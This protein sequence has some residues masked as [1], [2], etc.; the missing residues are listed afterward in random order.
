MDYKKIG[1]FIAQE[2]KVKNLTQEALAKKLYVSAKTISKWE[3]GNG[4]PD[5]SILTNLCAILEVT[6]N[7]LL[8][9][10]RLDDVDYKEKAENNIT[11]IYEEGERK[12]K[13]HNKIMNWIIAFIVATIYITVSLPT[14]K[15]EYTWIIWLVYCVYRIIVEYVFKYIKNK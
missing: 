11:T 3:N 14:Q 9:G 13:K 2:R 12:I 5:T 4:L 15:W 6:V 7:E 10:E 1:L 8:S